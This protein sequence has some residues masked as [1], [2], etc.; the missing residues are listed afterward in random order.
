MLNDHCRLQEGSRFL[1]HVNIPNIKVLKQQYSKLE[2]QRKR[3]Y[4]HHSFTSSH[5]EHLSMSQNET[6]L[7]VK[8]Q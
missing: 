3:P 4:N 8:P 5:F 2:K 6:K 7:C 1:V